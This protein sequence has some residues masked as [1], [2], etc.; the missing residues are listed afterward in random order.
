[1]I[2]HVNTSTQPG[3]YLIKVIISY[4]TLQNS[5]GI[6]VI[7]KENPTITDIIVNTPTQLNELRSKIGE[8]KSAG[9]DVSY[10][11]SIVT[12][13]QNTVQDSKTSVQE[14]DLDSLK[15]YENTIKLD[16]EQINVEL[17]R[18]A[19]QKLIYENKYNIADGISIGIISVY[20]IVRVLVPFV[21]ISTEITKLT[22]QQA[23]LINTRKS[24]EKQY[25][26]RTIDEPTFRKIVTDVHA[27]V[28]N[29][30]STINLKKQQRIDLVKKGLNP[31][32]LGE[33][34]KKKLSKK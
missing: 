9:L 20:L 1:V 26:T 12:K 31:L 10:L 32:T 28:M 18:L 15:Q 23:S 19:F 8:Y 34:I 6:R 29:L 5:Q 13:I 21:R 7:V 2:I 22:F 11:E 17:D 33:Y 4:Y 14:D 24:T 27:K 30:T 3:D 25:F 16:M